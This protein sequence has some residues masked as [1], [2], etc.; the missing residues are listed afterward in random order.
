ML[1][2]KKNGYNFNNLVVLR[3]IIE[4][5]YDDILGGCKLNCDNCPVAKACGDVIRVLNYLNDEIKK[6]IPDN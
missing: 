6:Q 3:N 5:G 4:N 1:T 2:F